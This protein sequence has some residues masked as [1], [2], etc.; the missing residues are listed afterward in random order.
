[1]KWDCSFWQWIFKETDNGVAFLLRKVIYWKNKGVRHIGMSQKTTTTGDVAKTTVGSSRLKH[2][3]FEHFKET[4]K[5][6]A[7]PTQGDKKEEKSS[8][9]TRL[10]L[11]T[12]C[13]KSTLR[14]LQEV[15]VYKSFIKEEATKD[16]DRSKNDAEFETKTQGKVSSHN[17]KPITEACALNQS[18][19]KPPNLAIR[20]Y[21]LYRGMLC[22]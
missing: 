19:A 11:S 1:M 22:Q 8:G 7:C 18:R 16:L 13:E 4:G 12:S 14:K 15:N 3:K 10:P 6:R 9:A 20:R 17:T 2:L 21:A 5:Q